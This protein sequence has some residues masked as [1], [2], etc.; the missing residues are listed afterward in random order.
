MKKARPYT[1]ITPGSDNVTKYKASWQSWWNGL[2]PKWRVLED[3]S[4]LREVSPHTGEEWNSL[5]KS[6]PCGFF[7]L[8]IRFSWWMNAMHGKVDD[9]ELC[10]ALNDLMWVVKCMTA[11]HNPRIHQVEGKWVREG[12]PNTSGKRWYV[13]SFSYYFSS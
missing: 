2:Q 7:L 8:V 11:T 9:V 3:G 13:L 10:S 6:G 1:I 4:L 5:Q 12:E